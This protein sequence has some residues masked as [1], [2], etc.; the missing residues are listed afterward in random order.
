MYINIYIYISL[1][2]LEAPPDGV[3]LD[4]VGVRGMPDVVGVADGGLWG[5]SFANCQLLFHHLVRALAVRAALHANCIEHNRTERSGAGAAST[6]RASA[7]LRRPLAH[8][9]AGARRE[10]FVGRSNKSFQ[11]PTFQNFT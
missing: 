10:I 6:R 8:A 9:A 3:E 4:V 5:W 2:T 1:N 7:P 11:H